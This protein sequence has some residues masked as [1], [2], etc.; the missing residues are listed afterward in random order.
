MQ[1][2]GKGAIGYHVHIVRRASDAA[3][4][5]LNDAALLMHIKA[6][7]AETCGG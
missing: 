2:E 3:R 6:I 7:H 5:Y 4:R 1:R